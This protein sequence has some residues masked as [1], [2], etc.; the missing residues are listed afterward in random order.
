MMK[1]CDELNFFIKDDFQ[2]LG[3]ICNSEGVFQINA[4]IYTRFICKTFVYFV[5]A[6]NDLYLSNKAHTTVQQ[7]YLNMIL[8]TASLNS[9]KCLQPKKLFMFNLMLLH[10][11][12][13]LFHSLIFIQLIR[14]II[15][16]R[17]FWSII[18]F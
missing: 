2:E 17:Y 15:M 3:Y 4:D 13:K 1:I 7:I 16:F 12:C 8:L 9:R 10:I 11:I 5:K 14:Y 6:N 18:C